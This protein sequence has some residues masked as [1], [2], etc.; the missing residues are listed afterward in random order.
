MCVCVCIGPV[1]PHQIDNLRNWAQRGVFN[2]S[3]PKN[4]RSKS[5]AMGMRRRE[6]GERRRGK[7]GDADV[8]KGQK[9]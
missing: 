3:L 2:S 4:R 1:L 6:T 9:M 7:H 5:D 8:S